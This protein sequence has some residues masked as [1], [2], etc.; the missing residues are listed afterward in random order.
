MGRIYVAS[1]MM[2]TMVMMTMMDCR[3]NVPTLSLDRTI[4]QAV[5]FRPFVTETWAQS[6]VSPCGICGGKVAMTRVYFR[7]ISPVLNPYTCIYC[8][9][10]MTSATDSVFKGNTLK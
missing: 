6:Q 8:R 7:I 1:N 2:T 4:V 3:G 5:S 10:Y 9:R